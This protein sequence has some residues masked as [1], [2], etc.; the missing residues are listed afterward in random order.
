MGGELLGDPL[1]IG[2]LDSARV[3]VTMI[4]LRELHNK[5][6]NFVLPYTKADLKSEIFMEAP[7]TFG[8]ELVPTYI[9]DH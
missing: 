5:S 7:I 3:I 2:Q 9:M 4:I 1:H 8:V 6:V